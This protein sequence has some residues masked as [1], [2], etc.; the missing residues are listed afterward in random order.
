MEYLYHME[1]LNTGEQSCPKG[2]M[3]VHTDF[4]PVCLI[5]PVRFSCV[6]VVQAFQQRFVFFWVYFA[7]DNCD[8][9]R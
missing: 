2:F 8:L 9:W 3:L 5:T 7:N 6:A 4:L 1:L